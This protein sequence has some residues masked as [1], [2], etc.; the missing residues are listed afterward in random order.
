[1]INKNSL[2]LNIIQNPSATK[3]KLNKENQQQEIDKNKRK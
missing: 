3:T 1:M 2:K